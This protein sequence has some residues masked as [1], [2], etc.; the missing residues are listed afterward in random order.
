MFLI[1]KTPKMRS[2]VAMGRDRHSVLPAQSSRIRE[3]T[4]EE[5]SGEIPNKTTA[6]GRKKHWTP[7]KKKRMEGISGLD[8]LTLCKILL[9]FTF[10]SV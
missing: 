10:V 5:E 6:E 3:E 9:W 4:N 8:K 2:S 7:W 1:D